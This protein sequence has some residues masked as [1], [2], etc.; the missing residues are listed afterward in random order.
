MFASKV[1]IEYGESGGLEENSNDCRL[2]L[3]NF[4]CLE[5][6]FESCCTRE[7]IKLSAVNPIVHRAVKERAIRK[8][9]IN[10][11]DWTEIWDTETIFKEFGEWIKFL[12]I[13]E[14]NICMRACKNS[15]AFDFFLQLLVKYCT[16]NRIQTISMAFD[17]GKVNMDLLDA[18]KPLFSNLHQVHFSSIGRQEN[19]GHEQLFAAIIDAATELESIQLENTW[20][21]GTWLQK[22]KMKNIRY[23]ALINSSIFDQK[24]LDTYFNQKPA[25][26]TFAWVNVSVPNHSL[27]ERF[28]RNCPNLEQLI[29]VQ[30]LVTDGYLRE[31]FLMNR[32]NYI[33]VAENLKC[34]RVTAFT[35]SG[36]DLISLFAAIA[37]KNTIENLSIHFLMNAI[38]LFNYDA[39]RLD[40]YNKYPEFTA[41]KVLDIQNN[42]SCMFWSI[43]IVNFII[44]MINLN[45]V[46]L[47]GI[48]PMTP[49]QL[50]Q[51]ALAPK[52]LKVLKINNAVITGLYNSIYTIGQ[53][54]ENSKESITIVINQEQNLLLQRNNRS[55]RINE[56]FIKIIVV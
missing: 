8:R 13:R 48:E 43:I 32:Y 47:S 54:K 55:K 49:V 29:D 12:S 38:G 30:H 37:R 31:S 51:I 7:L 17:I 36:Q 35:R 24:S 39:N 16:E 2:G 3:L 27:C 25:I 11:D 26:K 40:I 45:E 23:L 5:K 28:V 42:S 15:T 53:V 41:L 22:D 20:S 44:D 50:T 34:L 18:A 14:D 52:N 1:G 46:R 56:D 4:D 21:K 10:F 6:I 19:F 33:S 9:L